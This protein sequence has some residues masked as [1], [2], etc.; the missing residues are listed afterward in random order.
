MTGEWFTGENIK[1]VGV[2]QDRTSNIK[3][4]YK[5]KSVVS[6]KLF[7]DINLNLKYSRDLQEMKVKVQTEYKKKNYLLV[8][9]SSEIDESES[10]FTIDLKWADLSYSLSANSSS[11]GIGTTKVEL[12]MDRIRDVHLD[13]W[14]TSQRFSK[15]FGIELKWDANRGI[16]FKTNRSVI[17]QNFFFF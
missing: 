10:L 12:H 7:E 1:F 5:L 13:V 4:Y 17:F 14:G 11:K 16:Y 6:S 3:R 9:E 15:V 8:V 2:Y